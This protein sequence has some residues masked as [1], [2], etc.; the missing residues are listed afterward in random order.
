MTGFTNVVS[1]AAGFGSGQALRADGTVLS[2]GGNFRNALGRATTASSDPTPAPV[3]GM[4]GGAL[5]LDV[6]AYPNLLRRAR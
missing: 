5:T 2:W 1:I 3:V 4:G 6:S